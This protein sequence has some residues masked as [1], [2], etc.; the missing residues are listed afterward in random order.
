MNKTIF[1]KTHKDLIA[2]LIKARKSARLKQAEV[3]EK[4]GRTQSYVSKIEA[5]QR[6]LDVVQ[7]S[8]LAAVYKKNLT[9]FLK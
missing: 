5:G 4:L 1:T 2:K 3:A 9:Y 7:L 6:R 8:E